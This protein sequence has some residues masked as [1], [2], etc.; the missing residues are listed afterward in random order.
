MMLE[1][2]EDDTCIF[3]N[4][5]LGDTGIIYNDVRGYWR[6]YMWTMWE[7][8]EDDTCFIHNDV[9]GGYWR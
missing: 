9:L 3:D 7:S 6:W 2:T 1:T 8:T 5:V 4:D